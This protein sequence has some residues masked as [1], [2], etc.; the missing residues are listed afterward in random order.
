MNFQ[1]ELNKNK[2]LFINR[3]IELLKIN[4]IYDETTIKEKAPFGDGI[5]HALTYMIELA[6]KDGFKTVKD[7]GY[8]G[9]IEYGTGEEIIGILCHLD[10]VPVGDDWSHDPFDP[11]TKDGKIFARGAMDDKGPTMAVYSA[12]KIIKELNIPL[13]NKIRIILGTDEET[14]WRGIDHYFQNYEMPKIGFAPDAD[15]PLIYGEKGIIHGYLKGNGFENEDV[16]MI[17]GGSRLNIVMD[18]AKAITRC[19]H[20]FAFY[21]YLEKHHLLGSFTQKNEL[22]HYEIIGTA[23]SRNGAI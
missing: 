15:F 8:A 9:H 22:Y 21:Q 4:S 23:D 13:K 14:G 11:I 20:S 19:D 3:L 1:N 10:V 5:E 17:S 6:T 2:E 16:V 12:L 18:K 7:G